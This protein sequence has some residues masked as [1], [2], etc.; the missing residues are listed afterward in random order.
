[1][2]Q[3]RSLT[4]HVKLLI[5]DQTSE[6][7]ANLMTRLDE[8]PPKIEL[9]EIEAKQS[10]NAAL[11]ILTVENKLVHYLCTHLQRMQ[12]AHREVIETVQ[13]N[14]DTLRDIYLKQRKQASALHSEIANLLKETTPPY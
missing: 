14:Y 1:M 5:Q 6:F 10:K 8:S 12:D 13:L 7:L 9:P 3:S 11:N 4:T 2:S